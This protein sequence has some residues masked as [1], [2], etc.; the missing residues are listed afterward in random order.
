RSFSVSE[1]RSVLAKTGPGSCSFSSPAGNSCSTSSFC[2]STSGFPFLAINSLRLIKDFVEQPRNI[3][4]RRYGVLIVHARRP[5][6]SQ[7]AHH[8]SSNTGRRA[9]QDQ[10]AHG[11]QGLIKADNHAHSFL[12]CI[13]ICSQ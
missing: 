2:S 7:R 9:D 8:F 12:L 3:R 11:W 1:T 6:H 13:E 5:Q 4:H 10:V